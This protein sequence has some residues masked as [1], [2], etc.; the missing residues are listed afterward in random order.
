MGWYNAAWLNRI[1]ITLASPSLADFPTLLTSAQMT[2]TFWANVLA[3]GADIVACAADGVTKLKRELVS[4]DTGAQTIELYVKTPLNATVIYIYYNNPAGAETNDADTWDANYVMVQH[5]NDYDTSHI[6]DSTANAN[7]GA[8]SGA[9]Q[10]IEAAGVFA[11]DK[12][13]TC[14]GA[15]KIN[16][17]DGVSMD[18]VGNITLEAFAKITTLGAGTYPLIAGRDSSVGRNYNIRAY[19][20]S[21]TFQLSI[22]IGGTGKD[23]SKSVTFDTNYHHIVGVKNGDTTYCYVDAVAGSGTSAAGDIDNNDTSFCIGGRTNGDRYFTGDISEVRLSNALRAGA[24]IAATYNN[25]MNN[26]TFA[27]G[28]DDMIKMFT[29]VID[30]TETDIPRLRSIRIIPEAIGILESAVRRLR[31]IRPTAETIGVIDAPLRRLWSIRVINETAGI[32]DSCIRRLASIRISNTELVGLTDTTVR[33]LRSVRV[34]SEIIN[35]ADVG[36]RRLRST[37]IITET[38]GLIDAL[39]CRM[40]SVRIATEPIGVVESALR[41]M[42]RVYISVTETV[43]ITD[44]Q[45]GWVRRVMRTGVHVSR[46]A[47][48]RT[49]KDHIE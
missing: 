37:R 16:C 18:I 31:S 24:W 1:K 10:P 29:E 36:A 23:A 15:N 13:Q 22:F 49:R 7:H 21:N 8:K 33:R 14:S 40:R 2:P 44:G 9:N 25:L 27:T 32:V 20:S 47:L 45:F 43:G 35:A 12:A 17:G 11:G 19:Q 48:T 38:V 4:I 42:R 39:G 28:A 34:A 41:A 3:S 30:L 26:A 46:M 5:M 6:H